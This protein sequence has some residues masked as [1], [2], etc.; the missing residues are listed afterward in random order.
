MMEEELA[1][2]EKFLI[3][4]QRNDKNIKYDNSQIAYLLH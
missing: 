3:F 4:L 1:K 2:K